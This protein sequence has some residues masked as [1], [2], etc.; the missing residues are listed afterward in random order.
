MTLSG[1]FFPSGALSHLGWLQLYAYYSQM[2]GTSE[3]GSAE[4]LCIPLLNPPQPCP[5]VILAPKG[6]FSSWSLPPPLWVRHIAGR[7]TES[8]SALFPF[9]LEGLT[10]QG[11]WQSKTVNLP[12][13][14][15]ASLKNTNPTSIGVQ[16][17]GEVTFNTQRR[18][19]ALEGSTVLIRGLGLSA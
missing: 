10:A 4:H 11:K 18:P 3:L 2:T 13:P 7:S 8:D 1:L 14:Q 15:A 9:T 6:G 19:R 17:H 16:H 12:K 5:R